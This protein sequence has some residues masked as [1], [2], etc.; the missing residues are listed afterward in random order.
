MTAVIDSSEEALAKLMLEGK[1]IF[2]NDEEISKLLQFPR[3][4]LTSLFLARVYIGMAMQIFD[5][6]IPNV[7]IDNYESVS[8]A[9]KVVTFENMLEKL[10]ESE[11]SDYASKDYI[12]EH[13]KEYLLIESFISNLINLING[14]NQSRPKS[15]EIYSK[16]AIKRLLQNSVFN[17]TTIYEIKS[18]MPLFLYEKSKYN[19][20]ISGEELKESTK[21]FENFVN[22]ELSLIK[23][24]SL[25]SITEIENFITVLIEKYNT[26]IND[27]I[28]GSFVIKFTEYL[29]VE[30]I[31]T[32]MEFTNQ[33][34]HINIEYASAPEENQE[35]T[36]EVSEE[37]EVNYIINQEEEENA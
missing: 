33:E 26:S 21:R 18:I 16:L 29:I 36:I 14:K 5:S 32:K 3:M 37:K 8:I 7:S 27:E 30:E 28:R 19:I 12:P 10:L 9:E 13:T 15:I 22:N 17:K 20:S 35:F 23:D 25:N 6:S 1:E 4:E 34:I 11:I 24:K 31:N 2:P